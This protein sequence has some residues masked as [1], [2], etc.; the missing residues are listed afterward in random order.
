MIFSA[1]YA[2]MANRKPPMAKYA[3]IVRPMSAEVTGPH[4][5]VTL[6][7]RRVS[8]TYR[9]GGDTYH[10]LH[11]KGQL[12]R[13]DVVANLVLNHAQSLGFRGLDVVNLKPKRK[14]A[15][16]VSEAQMGL[17]DLEEGENDV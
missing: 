15:K 16:P 2:P 17:F 7:G 8:P 10:V 13:H 11:Y 5:D 1:N 4:E 12:I 14:R 9:V 6:Y 3:V